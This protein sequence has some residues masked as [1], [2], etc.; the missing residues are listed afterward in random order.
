VPRAFHFEDLSCNTH[1]GSSTNRG[2]SIIASDLLNNSREA[3]NSKGVG[4]PTPDGFAFVPPTCRVLGRHS[5]G[6]RLTESSLA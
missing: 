6:Y 2:Q 3:T 4:A 1:P 5:L